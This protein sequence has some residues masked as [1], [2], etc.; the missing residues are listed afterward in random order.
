MMS[1]SLCIVAD[2]HGGVL[3]VDSRVLACML[4]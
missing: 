2:S 1:C 3:P 4:F